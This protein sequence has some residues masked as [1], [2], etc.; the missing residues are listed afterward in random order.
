VKLPP[1]RLPA[2]YG[3]R[4]LVVGLSAL[5]V[6]GLAVIVWLARSQDVA[7][8]APS[9]RVATGAQVASVALERTAPAPAAG[10]APPGERDPSLVEVCGLGWVEAKADASVIEPEVLAQIPGM[11]AS[12][13]GLVGGLRESADAYARAT[14]L[15]LQWS[16]DPG[17]TG[18]PALD[19]LAREALTSDDARVYA[20][21]FRVCA[22]TP[23]EGSCAL[24][25]VG[26]WARLDPGN[27]E[28]WLFL[29]DDAAAR[30]DRAQIDEALYRIGSAARFEDRF[31]A[32]AGPIVA[33]A[34]TSDSE[35]MAAQ[36]L[37]SQA[38]GVAAALPLPVQRLMAACG[39]AQLADVNRRQVCDA[40]AAT[41]AE[42]SDSMLLAL[43]GSRLGQRVGWPSERVVATRMLSVALSD[44]WSSDTTADPRFGL[45]YS[46]SG[47]RTT[48]ARFGELARVGE[49]QVARAWIATGRK[50]PEWYAG[51]ARE[52]EARRSARE[53]E[54]AA[55]R[56][57]PVKPAS[58]AQ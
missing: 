55:R 20:L 50:P 13:Q 9:V 42:R 2:P 44:A 27:A 1:Y 4:P 56:P 6:V 24:L 35:L 49:P 5:A 25:N 22:R 34:G 48:L 58:V 7:P 45:S 39:G 37:A 29:L 47:V 8:A 26:Q 40:V 36:V 17:G 16:R 41:L 52:Q 23:A 14:A 15:V 43:V 19:Q 12:L 10:V 53:T 11:E 3:I 38:I 31:H 30:N 21:A 32:L 57:E 51:I 18:V 46:C 28:P 33:Q 54:D